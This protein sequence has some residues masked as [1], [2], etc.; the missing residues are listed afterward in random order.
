M[1]NVDA[2][3]TSL[4]G[5]VTPLAIYFIW[6]ILGPIWEACKARVSPALVREAWRLASSRL[7]NS[8]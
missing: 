6:D 4:V 2:R 5:D 3:Q 7:Y 1:P 8:G